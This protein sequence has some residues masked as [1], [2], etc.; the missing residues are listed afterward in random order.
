LTLREIDLGK[1]QAILVTETIALSLEMKN[2][3]ESRLV[4]HCGK[5]KIKFAYRKKHLPLDKQVYHLVLID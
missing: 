5:V 4:K 2:S 3:C 1:H